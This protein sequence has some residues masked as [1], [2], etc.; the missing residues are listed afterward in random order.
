MRNMGLEDLLSEE[1]NKIINQS[2]NIREGRKVPTSEDIA[3][4][5]GAVRLDATFLY[6][7]L[8]QSSYL[9][10][11]FQQRTAAKVIRAVLY[12]MSR[13]I[14]SFSGTVTSFDGDRVMGI[15]IDNYKN[16]NGAKCALKM[17]YAVKNILNPK[18]TSHFQS[19][20]RD[21]FDISHCVGVDTSPVLVVRAG[22]RGSNDL[23]WIGRAPNLA[24]KLSDIRESPYSSFISDTVYDNMNDSSKFGGD[25]NRNMWEKRSVDFRGKKQIVYRSNWTW[26]P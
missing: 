6:A 17:N 9:A 5:G 7:D 22:Q 3:L 11:E 13:I 2:W 19:L 26:T 10:T 20:K 15:F 24:A 8:S 21:G 14:T 23:V 4:A 12:N 18:L 25:N 16:T 1:T